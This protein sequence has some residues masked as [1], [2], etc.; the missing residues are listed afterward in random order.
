MKTTREQTDRTRN[1]RK[2][3]CN[4]CGAPNWSNQHECI[5]RMKKCIKC[6]K[7]GYYAKSCRSSRR[8]N[9]VAEDET[10]SAEDNDWTSDRI[11][12]IQQKIHPLGANGKKGPLF[13]TTTLVVNNRPIKLIIDLGSPVPLIPKSKFN[14]TTTKNTVAR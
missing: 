5:A 8:I 7:I 13:Y 3:D 14:I 1:T 11:H 6:S 10:Y 9:H 2:V 12:S 4:R